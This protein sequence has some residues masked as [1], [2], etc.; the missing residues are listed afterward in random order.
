MAAVG[1]P[2][3]EVEDVAKNSADRRAHRVQDT[4]GAVGRG[5]GHRSP[6]RANVL[7][8][9]A[10]ATSSRQTAART[11]FIRQPLGKSRFRLRAFM[12]NKT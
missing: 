10:G 9:K 2:I 7:A 11:P 6:P 3:G 12:V 5:H 4:K 1:L 8:G